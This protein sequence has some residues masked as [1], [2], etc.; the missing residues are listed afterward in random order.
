M[1]PDCSNKIFGMIRKEGLAAQTLRREGVPSPGG[2]QGVSHGTC[3]PKRHAE[4][5]LHCGR[6]TM[7]WGAVQCS[8]GQQQLRREGE[9]PA[10]GWAGGEG[11]LNKVGIFWANSLVH[12]KHSEHKWA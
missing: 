11:S 4:Q 12:P 6:S 9:G 1:C 8:W 3:V 10:G 2:S 5:D 7:R